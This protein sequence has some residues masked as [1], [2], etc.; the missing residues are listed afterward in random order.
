MANSQNQLEQLESKIN[1]LISQF[2]KINTENSALRHQVDQMNLEKQQLVSKN[3]SARK[4]IDLMIH[5]LRS[6]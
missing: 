3:D 1:A 6:M 5:R 2:E 4:Q